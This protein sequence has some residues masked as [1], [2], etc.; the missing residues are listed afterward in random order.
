MLGLWLIKI[1]GE[2]SDSR[3]ITLWSPIILSTPRQST[4]WFWAHAFWSS[5]HHRLWSFLE[6]S[7][8]NLLTLVG[9]VRSYLNINTDKQPTERSESKTLSSAVH[10]SGSCEC[11]EKNG[12]TKRE[13]GATKTSINSQSKYTGRKMI[14]SIWVLKKGKSGSLFLK[15]YF[16][17]HSSSTLRSE[18]I[19]RGYPGLDSIYAKVSITAASMR[20]SNTNLSLCKQTCS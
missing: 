14:S 10:G 18:V 9:K 13:G 5:Y 1:T 3:L 7:V 19:H 6:F 8:G 11:R 20:H 12:K 2:K 17:P 15:P 16:S 4:E